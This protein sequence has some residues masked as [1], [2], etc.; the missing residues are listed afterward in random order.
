[1]K[2]LQLLHTI[3][4]ITRSQGIGSLRAHCWPRHSHDVFEVVN[5]SCSISDYIFDLGY[6]QA[7]EN[8]TKVYNDSR[9]QIDEIMLEERDGLDHW[10]I[11]WKNFSRKGYH[12]AAVE[13]NAWL[14]LFNYA[15]P[16]FKDKPVDVFMRSRLTTF[17]SLGLINNGDNSF[18]IPKIALHRSGW[19]IK[20]HDFLKL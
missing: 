5:E 13:D 2:S 9:L 15:L 12:T 4:L 19:P 1:M 8:M 7:N 14:G 18:L 17:V 6:I 11:I 16:G 3:C 10:P 20:T